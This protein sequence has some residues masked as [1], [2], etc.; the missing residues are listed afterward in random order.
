MKAP[1]KQPKLPEG[2]QRLRGHIEEQW[3]S[4]A[5]EVVNA[6]EL[7]LRPSSQ[8]YFIIK[9]GFHQ[10]WKDLVIEAL[11]KRANLPGGQV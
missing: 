11:M 9:E 7:D 10:R 4:F 8:S 3:D 2:L 5:E 1:K 6:I